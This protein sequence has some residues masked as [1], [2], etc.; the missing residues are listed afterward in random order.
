MVNRWLLALLVMLPAWG[1]PNHDAFCEFRLQGDR[2]VVVW[3]APESVLRS[4]DRNGDG[5]VGEEEAREGLSSLLAQGF[6]AEVDGVR[7]EP[8][9][10]SPPAQ[11]RLEAYALTFA[12]DFPDEVEG[13]RLSYAL[14]DT[15][16]SRM[17]GLVHWPDAP[18]PFVVT[19]EEPV[20][21]FVPPRPVAPESPPQALWPALLLAVA[22]LGLLG[23]LC[24]GSFSGGK[25]ASGCPFGFAAGGL[26]GSALAGFALADPGVSARSCDR[27]GGSRRTRLSA[28]WHLAVE[29]VSDRS[30]S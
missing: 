29:K 11:V 26:G 25:L 28:W 16:E 13:F 22:S 7:P 21:Q 10:V 18:T 17:T 27:V 23:W 30:S 20:F 6:F 12:W 8:E 1:H 19:P 3:T 9:L 15:P 2:L 14:F 4:L 5:Q 24:S